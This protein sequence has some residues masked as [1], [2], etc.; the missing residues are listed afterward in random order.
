MI[1]MA[2]ILLWSPLFAGEFPT[3]PAPEQEMTGG[4]FREIRI[5]LLIH[6]VDYLWSNMH[7]EGGIDFN[8]EVLF[9]VPRI[10]IFSGI[11]LPNLGLTINDRGNT[12]KVYLGFLWEWVFRNGFFL[13][14][15]LGAAVHNG[16]LSPPAEN[17]K[18]LGSR[19]LFRIPFEMGFRVSRR[20]RLSLMFSHVSNGY[21]A[22]Y[23]EGLDVLGL[24]L[25]Y[26][27]Y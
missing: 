27:F 15:G 22:E 13:D 19:V 12:S 10:R 14:L 8:A 11:I 6:D 3:G 26:I 17:R 23:N 16:E 18:L 2:G 4:I 24:R 5:G 1:S 20:L 25:G 21:T 9:S 7:I